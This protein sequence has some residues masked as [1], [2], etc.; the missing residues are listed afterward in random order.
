MDTQTDPGITIHAD[1]VLYRSHKDGGWVLTVEGGEADK[2]EAKKADG[3]AGKY[4]VE[5]TVRKLYEKE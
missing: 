2:E 4:Y 3:L 5:V 1:S